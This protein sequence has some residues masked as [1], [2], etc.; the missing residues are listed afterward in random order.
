M[1]FN[2]KTFDTIKT[3]SFFVDYER[4]FNFLNYKKSSILTNATKSRIKTLKKIH[5]NIM[6]MQNKSSKYVN[7]KRKN[8]SLLKEEDKIYFFT[9]NLKRKNKSKKLNSIK[10]EAFLVRKI[11]KLKSYELHLF[12]NVK[13]HSIFNIFLLKLIDLNIFIQET[14]YYKKQKEEKFEIEKIFKKKENQYLIK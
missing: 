13:I 14:F 9:K 12:K 8:V 11:K 7:D 6:K 2:I 5:D 4:N 10:V 3:T 1:T